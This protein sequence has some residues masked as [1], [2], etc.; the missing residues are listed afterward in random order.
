MILRAGWMP[1][2]PSYQG[3]VFQLPDHPGRHERTAASSAPTAEACGKPQAARISQSLQM[4]S[5]NTVCGV[6]RHLTICNLPGDVG[7]IINHR[8]TTR[9]GSFN[10]HVPDDYGWQTRL[11]PGHGGKGFSTQEHQGRRTLVLDLDEPWS[12]VARWLLEMLGDRHLEVTYRRWVHSPE[13]T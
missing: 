5:G 6:N 1:D 11:W 10:H 9:L 7:T 4:S 3:R 8:L 12:F 13:F 2:Y